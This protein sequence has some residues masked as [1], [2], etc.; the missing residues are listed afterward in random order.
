[1]TK[2]AASVQL[3]MKLRNYF[4]GAIA[5]GAV[6]TALSPLTAALR[7]FC[8]DEHADQILYE[9]VLRRK[10]F[11]RLIADL[12]R[13]SAH[14]EPEAGNGEA[15]I[16]LALVSIMR[17]AEE[18]FSVQSLAHLAAFLEGFTGC[19]MTDSVPKS[20]RASSSVDRSARQA[21]QP[22]PVETAPQ[23]HRS[24]PVLLEAMNMA[25]RQGL[26]DA[27]SKELV[28]GGSPSL[29]HYRLLDRHG[30]TLAKVNIQMLKAAVRT[31]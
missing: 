22:R 7:D 29:I 24:D 21:E 11:H 13:R 9:Y 30:A 26:L 12:A 5:S 20:E 3:G 10:I 1:M 14:V 25:M 28:C 8:S 4:D 31:S 15:Q 18:I 6:P 23:Q 27:A 2:P 17:E 16:R 19:P